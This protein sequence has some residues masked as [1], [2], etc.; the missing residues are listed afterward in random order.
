MFVLRHV[1]IFYSCY[2]T[3]FSFFQGD[4]VEV[5]NEGKLFSYSATNVYLIA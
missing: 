3:I 5:N 1:L 2:N 4:V